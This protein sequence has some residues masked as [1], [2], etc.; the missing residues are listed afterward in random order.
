M[1]R[2][3]GPGGH[4]GAGQG[5][6]FFEGEVARHRHER[7][8]AQHGGFRQH[9]VKVGTRPVGQVVG[10]QRSA[11]PARMEGADN[12]VAHLDQCH[13]FAN[14]S[15]LARAVGKRHDA[16]LCWTATAAFEDHQIAV[17]ERAR[18]HSRQDL[19]RPGP[20]IFARSQHDPFTCHAQCRSSAIWRPDVPA[21]LRAARCGAVAGAIAG[22][23][24]TA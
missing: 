12:P 9:P 22:A 4:C 15:D 13:S 20:G 14:G 16:E 6:S 3:C 1:A 2:Q 5:R 18:A 17:I 11:E 10:A 23:C 21:P 19:V 24:P 7:F 8:L